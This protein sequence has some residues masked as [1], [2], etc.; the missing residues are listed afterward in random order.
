MAVPNAPIGLVTQLGIDDF[1]FRRGK[2]FGTILV[3]LQSRQVLDL[4]PDRTAETSAAWMATHPE[5]DLVSRD[6]G[7]DYATGARQGAPQAL[8]V[9]D[10]FHIVKNLTE[11]VELALAQYRP[12][13]LQALRSEHETGTLSLQTNTT[14]TTDEIR[15]LP[16]A[17]AQAAVVLQ[18]IV[19]STN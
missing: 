5:I 15:S 10:R 19:S 6:R 14:F 2:K 1:S 4:L 16:D 11:A 18:K 3:D 17:T 12:E 8:Q 9:A 13:I 7:G